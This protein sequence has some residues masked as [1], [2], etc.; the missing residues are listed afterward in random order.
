MPEKLGPNQRKEKDQVSSA[1][2]NYFE[3]FKAATTKKLV[4]KIVEPE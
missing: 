2:K 3:T 1:T 4:T